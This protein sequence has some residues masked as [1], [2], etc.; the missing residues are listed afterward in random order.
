VWD[1]LECAAK[2]LRAVGLGSVERGSYKWE[3]IGGA[4]FIH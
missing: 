1:A 2:A 4:Y 3:S